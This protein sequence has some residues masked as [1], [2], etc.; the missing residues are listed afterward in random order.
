LVIVFLP[1]METGKPAAAEST[2]VVTPVEPVVS[3]EP[4]PAQEPVS[5]VAGPTEGAAAAD[6]VPATL[7]A[8]PTASAMSAEGQA[9][10]APAV[11]ASGALLS[12]AATGE[13]WIEVVNGSGSVVV[14]RM[15]QAGDAVDFSSTP[16]YTVVLGRA[17]VTQV[18]VRGKPFDLARHARNNVARF[19]VR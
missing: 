19:E 5:P 15:L 18:T 1:R 4:V 2:N 6:A 11:P 14:Q 10:P 8:G 17:D 12:I 13:S 9:M 3:T 7:A 16:P